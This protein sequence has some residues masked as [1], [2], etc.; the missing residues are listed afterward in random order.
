MFVNKFVAVLV[1]DVPILCFSFLKNSLACLS[2][3]LLSNAFIAS[4]SKRN[5]YIISMF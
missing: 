3:N 2:P 5:Y 1:Y 4:V